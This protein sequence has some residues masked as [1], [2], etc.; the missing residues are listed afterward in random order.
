MYTTYSFQDVS[1]VFSHP[2]F[3]RYLAQGEG[4]GQITIGM[5]TDRTAHDVAADGTVMVSKI[6]GRNGTVTIQAQQTSSLHKWLLLLY[7]Y[8]EQ[9]PASAWAKLSI[10]VRSPAMLDYYE[11]N[12]CSF[13]KIPDKAYQAT[14]Q[15]IAWSIMAA[16]IFQTVA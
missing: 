1:V 14:G 13:L 7:N 12:G 2:D 9:A 6:A 4:L 10:V 8:L 16:D 3:G 5:A 15:Q 11:C